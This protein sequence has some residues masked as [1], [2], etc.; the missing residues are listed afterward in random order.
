MFFSVLAPTVLSPRP[1]AGQRA[2]DGQGSGGLHLNR[3][4]RESYE[5]ESRWVPP[6]D[7]VDYRSSQ[8]LGNPVFRLD[9]WSTSFWVS[10]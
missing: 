1:A 3:E 10:D 9:S 5:W 8:S 4:Q 6:H 2:F 7:R